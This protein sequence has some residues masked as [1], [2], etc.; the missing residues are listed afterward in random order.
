MRWPVG[1]LLAAML[2][3]AP[4]RAQ[5]TAAQVAIT[6]PA[7]KALDDE[8]KC[9]ALVVYWEGKNESR[10]GQEAVAHTVLNRTKTTR[11][12]N[13]I[14]DVVSQKL[15][16][17]KKG[18]C[19]FSWWCDGKRDDPKEDDNWKDAVEVARAVRGGQTKDATQGALYF[20]N[21]KIKPPSWASSKKRTVRIGD[22][23]F[24]R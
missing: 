23:I 21:A 11:F 14:C 3:T 9:L 10:A 1:L 13:T 20:H 5:E 18:R 4:V 16:G 19:Q 15:D 22:H 7:A 6:E 24:Y 12:P 17:A 8:T 2:I